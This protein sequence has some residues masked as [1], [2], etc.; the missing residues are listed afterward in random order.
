[1]ICQ[2]KPSFEDP[3][4]QRNNVRMF[5]HGRSDIILFTK[6]IQTRGN[7]RELDQYQP[8]NF[9]SG[10]QLIQLKITL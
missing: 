4:Q 8:P 1:M 7:P 9:C 3:R 5:Q 2:C 10:F 6:S